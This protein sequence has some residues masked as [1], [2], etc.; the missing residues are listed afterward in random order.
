MTGVCVCVCVCV[1]FGGL[2]GG[3][4][5]IIWS[6]EHLFQGLHGLVLSLLGLLAGCLVT[7]GCVEG[8]QVKPA[9]PAAH[10]S[11]MQS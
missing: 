1:C 6:G 4:G 8:I 7:R 5:V 3:G 9:T 11:M 10:S 2:G